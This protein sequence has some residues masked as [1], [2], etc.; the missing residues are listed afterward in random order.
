[1][2]GFLGGFLL[3]S[4]VILSFYL[5]GSYT[6][7][8]VN[9]F[10]VLT[11][12]LIIFIVM[13]IWEEVIFRGIIFRITESKLGTLRALIISSLIFGFVHATNDNFNFLSSLA[14][15]LE[16]GLLTGITYSITRR[17]W[18]PIAFTY[19]LEY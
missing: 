14:V 10:S 12:P 13:G 5:I 4:F 17:L 3:I 6:V 7:T 15:A 11:K 9:H 2:F 8:S 18:V 16:L 19:R 1:M